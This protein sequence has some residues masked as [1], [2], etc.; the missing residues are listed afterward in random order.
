M[1]R[2]RIVPDPADTLFAD[3]PIIGVHR[4]INMAKGGR[5]RVAPT[6]EEWQHIQQHGD[7]RALH[8]HEPR[9]PGAAD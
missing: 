4:E 6:D 2:K 5:P 8:G 3:L 7:H 1:A 9:H